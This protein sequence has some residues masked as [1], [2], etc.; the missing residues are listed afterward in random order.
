MKRFIHYE[1]DEQRRPMVTHCVL[2]DE[3][4]GRSSMGTAVCSKHDQPVKKVGQLIAEGRAMKGLGN[5][6]DRVYANSGKRK[7]IKR[8]A[9]S[10]DFIFPYLP[11]VGQKWLTHMATQTREGVAQIA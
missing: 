2:F 10:A 4:T 5:I 11:K 1:R 7:F 3:A 9:G 8:I 6:P